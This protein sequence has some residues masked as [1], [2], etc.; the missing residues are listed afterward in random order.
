MLVKDFTSYVTSHGNPIFPI[1]IPVPARN[2]AQTL[3]SPGLCSGQRDNLLQ[4][5]DTVVPQTGTVFKLL[6][7]AGDNAR[8]AAVIFVI[9]NVT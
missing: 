2:P 9:F 3:L 8:A 4:A 1:F 7:C 5:R 6:N